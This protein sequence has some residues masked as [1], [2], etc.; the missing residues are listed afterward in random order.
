MGAGNE[1]HALYWEYETRIGRRWNE[2]PETNSSESP[3][4]VLSNSPIW[5]NDVMGDWPDGYWEKYW[6]YYWNMIKQG[7]FPDPPDVN[8]P[9]NNGRDESALVFKSSTPDE[10]YQR[11]QYNEAMSSIWLL[12]D[13]PEEAIETEFNTIREELHIEHCTA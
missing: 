7:M 10:Q 2:D 4:A 11:N 8:H 9:G 3:Y 6:K 12:L 1:N 5:K 13:N